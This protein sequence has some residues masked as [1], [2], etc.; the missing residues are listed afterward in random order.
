MIINQNKTWSVVWD[1][2]EMDNFKYKY[3]T[4]EE[5]VWFFENIDFLSLQFAWQLPLRIETSTTIVLII[6]IQY[7]QLVLF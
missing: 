4:E 7:I 2:T 5:R 6:V 3:I 1:Y